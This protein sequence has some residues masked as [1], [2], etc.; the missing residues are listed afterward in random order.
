MKK[1]R[2]SN[3]ELLRIIAMCLIVL[4]HAIIHGAFHNIQN[5]DFIYF[6]NNIINFTISNVLIFGGKVGVTIFILITGYF[7]KSISF[8]YKRLIPIFLQTLFYSL[9]GLSIGLLTGQ[10]IAIFT[11]L[12][13]FLPV[14]FSQYW[15]ITCYIVIILLS[16]FVIILLKNL[17]SK[18][19]LIL[20]TI[21][22]FINIIIPSLLP[23]SLGIVINDFFALIL[24]FITGYLINSYKD[25]LDL[26]LKNRKIIVI[27]SFLFYVSSVL[28][29]ELVAILL[30]SEVFK[31][32]FWYS[33][34][35]SILVFTFSIG[36]FLVFKE[37]KIKSSHLINNISS[38]MF[39]VYLIHDNIFIK[40]IL[41]NN[42]FDLY[43]SL[44]LNTTFF[45]FKIIFSVLS[46]LF[47]C[48]IVELIRKQFF[49][50][51]ESYLITF[52]WLK[53]VRFTKIY[54][55]FIRISKTKKI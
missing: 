8:S 27:F 46:I 38:L 53:I 33:S 36:I 1:I 9:V 28:F 34:L 20:F 12:K 21:L 35:S 40:N 50:K 49:S 29:I 52:E 42:I 48:S 41:W 19:N 24:I 54:D 26:I 47:L 5:F 32:A 16:P 7:S 4:H 44:S 31:K 14:I 51:P 37:L 2:D 13:Q 25:K 6:Q 3:L 11:I 22:L 43:D 45:L 55:I 10:K 17:N 23:K 15:F 30:K 18:E 39:G